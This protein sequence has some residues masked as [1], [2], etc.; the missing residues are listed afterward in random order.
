VNTSVAEADAGLKRG[1]REKR[2]R[3]GQGSHFTQVALLALIAHHSTISQGIFMN[4]AGL[5]FEA[6]RLGLL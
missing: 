4:N 1:G 6:S 3:Q 2:A 5:L